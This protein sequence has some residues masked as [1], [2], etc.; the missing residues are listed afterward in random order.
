MSCVMISIF[1]FIL[2][3]ANLPILYYCLSACDC[4][5]IEIVNSRLAFTRNQPL[6][7]SNMIR[8]CDYHSDFSSPESGVDFHYFNALY[9]YIMICTRT[10]I[11][12]SLSLR[13][14]R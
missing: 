10:I 11:G 2:S 3:F 6:G 5:I 12:R 8:F 13:K 9:P 1:C 14:G 7:G 4:A